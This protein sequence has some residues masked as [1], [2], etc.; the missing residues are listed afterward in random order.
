MI[1]GREEARLIYRGVVR[2]VDSPGCLLVI[3]IGGGSTE[4]IIGEG[5][6]PT[7]LDSLYMGCVS[8]TKRFFGGGMVTKNRMDEAV[9]AARRE[10]QSVV[11][12]YRKAGWNQV[13]GSSGTIVAIERILQAKGYSQI[14]PEGLA[15]LRKKLIKAV[16][17]DDVVLDGLTDNRRPVIAGG[18]AVLS[19]LVQGLRIDE[20]H[21]TRNALREGVLLELVGREGHSDIR[22]ATV[23]HLTARFEVDGRQ[24]FR[25]QQTALSLFD[26]VRDAWALSPHHRA[27]LRWAAA[28]HEAG[29][30]MTYSGYHKH[31]AYL[32]T[33]TEMPGFSRQ[34]QRYL[35]AIVLGHRGKPTRDKLAE[36]A[37]MWDRKLLHLVCLLRLASR[38]HRRRSPRPPPVVRASASNRS[39]TLGFPGAWLDERPL[40]RADLHEDARHLEGLG[41]TIA[42]G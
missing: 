42:I 14:D 4:L 34:E 32:L 1:S 19:A 8:W 2:D 27:L 31:G 28:L 33:H 9:L 13:V 40:S 30:V 12:A 20:L 29:M 11:R 17:V 25:V 35:A 18:V 39:L 22:E 7:Q 15:W 23:R 38:I 21:A 10:M 37:P 36:V 6:E 16:D 41:Y 3:D 5:S 24:S 26:Q